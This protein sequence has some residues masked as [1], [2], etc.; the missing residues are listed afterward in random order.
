M[1]HQ[2][3]LLLPGETGDGLAVELSLGR[4]HL[5]IVTPDESLGKWPFGDVTASR[6]HD[7]QFDLHLAAERLVFAPTDASIF[8]EKALPRFV[9]EER[10]ETPAPRQGWRD[11]FSDAFLAPLGARVKP[12]EQAPAPEEKPSESVA[13]NATET[14]ASI[15]TTEVPA[16]APAEETQSPR[17]PLV[18]A[19][20]IAEVRTEVAAP[21]EGPLAMVFAEEPEPP[22]P[23]AGPRNESTIVIDAATTESSLSPGPLD[24]ALPDQGSQGPEPSQNPES[25][26]PRAPDP[27]SEL[28][29]SSS[30]DGVEETA[31]DSS[32]F[33]DVESE[34]AGADPA[35][36]GAK[37]VSPAAADDHLTTAIAEAMSSDLPEV[38]ARLKKA[39]VDLQEKR[40]SSEEAH[41]MARLGQAICLAIAAEDQRSET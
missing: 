10:Q 20:E 36:D 30:S 11:R 41:A 31:L 18:A 39:L 15:E 33:I 22:S 32:T 9:V 1:K 6:I 25:D 17:G 35:D 5:E 2:G 38:I 7:D 34:S 16:S 13:D 37:I 4:T 27:F 19:S 14:A 3:K 12:H 23:S 8:A 28:P 26:A 24:A 40:I 29:S 21:S